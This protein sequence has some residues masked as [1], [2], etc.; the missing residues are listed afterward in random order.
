MIADLDRRYAFA[1]FLDDRT[2]LVAK[3]GRE[4]S[5]GVFS[6]QRKGV[7]MTHSRRYVADQNLAGFR[8]VQVDRLDLQWL[9]R[10]PGD[11]CTCLHRC[12]SPLVR[13]CSGRRYSHDYR[14]ALN[15]MRLAPL[16]VSPVKHCTWILMSCAS[17]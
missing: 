3:N 10:F 7:G 5:L 6:R 4:K 14:S 2:T 15:A 11:C 17:N 12:S 16:R 8:T 1:D 13:F 9:T